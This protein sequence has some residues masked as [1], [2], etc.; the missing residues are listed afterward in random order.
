[1]PSLRENNNCALGT[2]DA[3]LRYTLLRNAGTHYVEVTTSAPGQ[4]GTF[5]LTVDRPRPPST[6]DSLVQLRS[7]TLTPMPVGA[8]TNQVAVPLR[9]VP[10]DPDGDSVQ[11]EVE[12][13][14][15]NVA[16]TNVPT[17]VSALVASGRRAGVR[18]TGLHDDTGYHWQA[19]AVDVTGRRSAWVPFGNNDETAPDF[20][21][22][23]PQ[24]PA[25]PTGLA[26]FKD[27]GVTGIPVGGISN[28]PTAVFK[29]G[30]SD[31]DPGDQ[32]RLEVEVIP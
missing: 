6:P 27:D 15:V 11:V 29:A 16:F 8:A 19:R 30:L 4:T 20:S 5:T 13:Q 21:V 10:T 9:S 32:L 12:V 31:P 23:V 18:A 3:C 17:V 24:A 7:D 25:A 14:P 1:A 2:T 28:G 26:Q 22:A